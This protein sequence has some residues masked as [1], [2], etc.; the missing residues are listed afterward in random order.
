MASPSKSPEP[1]KPS[2]DAARLLA[3]RESLGLTREQA[4]ELWGFSP[5]TLQGWEQGFREPRG[6]SRLLILRILAE[7]EKKPRR[8]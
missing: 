3:L 5:K 1:R 4:G 7:A 2:E 6:P 8:K